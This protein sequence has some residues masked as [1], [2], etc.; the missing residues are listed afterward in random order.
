MAGSMAMGNLNRL[1]PAAAA[2]TSAKY[3]GANCN[4]IQ[5]SPVL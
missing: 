2:A 4:P 1:D 5:R 3:A